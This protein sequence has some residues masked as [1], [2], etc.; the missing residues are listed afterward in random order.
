M[1]SADL[2]DEI[3]VSAAQ[4]VSLLLGAS[5]LFWAFALLMK[6]F[7]QRIRM[8][9]SIAGF[10]LLAVAGSVTGRSML[11]PRPTLLAG[12]VVLSVLFLWEWLYHLSSGRGLFERYLRPIGNARVIV[13]HGEINYAALRHTRLD[14]RS[15]I[16]RLRRAGVM[17]LEDV[18]LAIL[19]TDGSVTIVR[20]GQTIDERLLED[21][22]GELPPLYVDN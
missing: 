5:V 19:E 11:G 17:S 22:A 12:L 20:S 18:E 3:G 21:V 6:F 2:W 10:A 15:L 9:G 13:F 1:S 7:G 14:Q 16:A 8:Q 4:L